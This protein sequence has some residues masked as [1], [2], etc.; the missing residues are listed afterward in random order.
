M[1]LP[2]IPPP[3]GSLLARLPQYPH[4]AALAAA[5]N[6]GLRELFSDH[7]MQR[8]RNKVV[9]LCIEDAGVRLTV[10]IGTT[11]CTPCSDRTQPDATISAAARDFALLA[12]R[13]EDPDTLF[14]DRRLR[15]EGDTELGLIVKNALDRVEPPLPESLV[16]AVRRRVT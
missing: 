4:S 3:L 16:D 7:E 10:R 11:G 2:A 14:F 13:K 1:R 15:I 9:R 5:L 6:L 12:L 8:V